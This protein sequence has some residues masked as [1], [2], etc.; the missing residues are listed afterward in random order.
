MGENP[1]QMIKVTTGSNISQF[2]IAL[3]GSEVLVKGELVKQ[4]AG[5]LADSHEQKPEK[6]EKEKVECATDQQAL[7]S[8][9]CSYYKEL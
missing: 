2:D 6:A 7:Y 1:D 9:E 3:E 8:I 4:I 5:M